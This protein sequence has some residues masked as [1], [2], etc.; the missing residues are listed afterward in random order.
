MRFP[1][2]ATR[3]ETVRLERSDGILECSVH[4]SGGPLRWSSEAHRELG[5]AFH[6]IGS[7]PDNDVVIFTGTGQE[8]CAD[9]DAASFADVGTPTGWERTFWEGT[10][11]LGNFLD[12]GVPV[13]SAINGPAVIHAEL[14]LL[15]DIALCA[16]TATFQDAAHFLLGGVPG[17]G[18]HIV[19][20]ALLGPNRG[21]YFLLTGQCITAS[22]ALSL[23]IVAEVLPSADLMARAR[24]L[25]AQVAARPRLTRRYTKSALS[26][27][28]KRALHDGLSQG[29]ALQGL[30]FQAMAFPTESIRGTNEVRT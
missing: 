2:Y 15:A 4:T 5:E 29:L 16:D 1:E 13:I 18:V 19:W 11:L 8:F 25:A 7:D 10:R 30:A 20:P 23:G 17:D 21:R 14:P 22:E 27:E 26:W 24:D 12:I 28:L 6:A 3:F 9:A